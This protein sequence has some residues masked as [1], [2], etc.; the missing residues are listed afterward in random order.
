MH[1]LATQAGV[2]LAQLRKAAGDPRAAEAAWQEFWP[3]TRSEKMR[4]ARLM[5]ILFSLGKRD[6][7]LGA[8]RRCADTLALRVG[9]HARCANDGAVS[10][11]AQ[12]L[13]SGRR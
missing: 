4:I 6:A 12:E 3:S 1:H 9:R 8:F 13:S 7:A 10:T 5:G 2:R 11:R